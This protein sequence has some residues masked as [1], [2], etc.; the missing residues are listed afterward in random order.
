[1]KFKAILWA[2][3]VVILAAVPAYSQRPA[4]RTVTNMDLE[5]YRQERLQAERDYA[6]NYDRMGF[7]SP[8]ELQKQIEKSRQERIALS[9]R[10]MDDRIQRERIQAE[11]AAA[12]YAAREDRYM[13]PADTRYFAWPYGGYYYNGIY[14]YPGRYRG[15]V[16]GGNGQPIF[17]YFNQQRP[18]QRLPAF[19]V[20]RPR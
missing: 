9:A 8:E 16:R 14:A 2:S 10:L 5:K 12:V 3:A 4:T 19:R 1:M 6:E 13:V 17:D 7:P 11:L 15:P 18:V 20:N